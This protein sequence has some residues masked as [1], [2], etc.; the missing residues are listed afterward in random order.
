M[1]HQL[2]LK[3]DFVSKAH[4][5]GLLDVNLSFK[6]LVFKPGGNDFPV[7]CTRQASWP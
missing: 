2:K 5:L 4:I 6:S 1:F 7:N 3:S